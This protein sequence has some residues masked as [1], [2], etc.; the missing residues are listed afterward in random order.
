ME[1]AAVIRTYLEKLG[2]EP[3]ATTVYIQL[4]RNGH[5]S[6]LQLA[7]T[8]GISRTQVYRHLEVLQRNNLVSAEQLSYG[9]LYRPLPL[10]NIEGLL[11]SREA[12]TAAIR[13]N[14]GAMTAA[15]QAIAGGSGPTASVQHYYG[16]AGLKQ[17]NWN[18]TKADKSYK[19]FEAAHI[20]VH[21]DKAFARRLR[22]RYIERQLT[23]YDLTNATKV[24]AREI[25]PFEPSRTFL[26]HINPEVLTINFE[27][28]LY[29]DVV[30]L[31]DYS[32]NAMAVEIHHPALHA[33]MEQLFDA[34]WVQATP[35]DITP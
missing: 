11:A 9:T 22:E 31:F 1:S 17:A 3:D 8:T 27:M 18:L 16:I 30:T 10:D 6:A 20:S 14:L 29:N 34:M 2:I 12:E 25:E 7:K 24:S 4:V 21:L 35:L 5:S 19:V 23:S 28:C 13:R 26:R 33:M 32:K 15:L